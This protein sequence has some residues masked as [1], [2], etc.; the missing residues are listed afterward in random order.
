V[1]KIYNKK[2]TYMPTD[3]YRY[4]AY[5]IGL[6]YKENNYIDMADLMSSLT[7]NNDILKT[8]GEI[9]SLNLSEEY[10]LDEINDYIDTIKE[11][12]VNYQI[13]KLKEKM[14]KEVDPLEQAKIAME[15]VKL[16]RGENND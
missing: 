16:K 11:Y 9:E 4:L 2:I 3:K 7:D 13:K 8:I 5:E 10:T 1:I 15:V 12:N 6:F 14:D